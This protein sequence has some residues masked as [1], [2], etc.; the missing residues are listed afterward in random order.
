MSKEKKL[1]KHY[2]GHRE[3]LRKRFEQTGFDG[4]HDYEVLELLLSFVIP[5]EDTK[6]TAKELL[7]KYKTLPNVL[8]AEISDLRMVKGIKQRSAQFLKI[9]SETIRFYFETKAK[10]QEIQFLKLEEL[11]QYLR[12]T[13]GNYKNEVF[14]ILYLN[15]KNE[16]IYTE[17]FGEGTVTEAIAFPRKIVEGALKHNA[18]TVI[19]AHNHPGGLAEPSENDNSI[20]QQIQNALKTVNITLQEHII[21]SDN[22]FYS[23]RKNGILI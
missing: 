4:F 3:R 22:G 21:I 15:S 18:T 14:K 6:P 19:I 23:Y 2:E 10:N 7:S 17:D 8:S 12:A 20:T 9:I 11:V 5:R 1:K 13:I 16:F